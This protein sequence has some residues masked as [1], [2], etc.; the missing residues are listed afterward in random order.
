[1]FVLQYP[2][3]VRYAHI[4]P[5]GQAA[6]PVVPHQER[7]GRGVQAGDP[8]GL[9]RVRCTPGAMASESK[10][11]AGPLGSNYRAVCVVVAGNE[12]TDGAITRQVRDDVSAALLEHSDVYS[13]ITRAQL[14]EYAK[15]K[16]WKPSDVTDLLR[17]LRAFMAGD[18]AAEQT[19]D[20][21][22]TQLRE[23]VEGV[24]AAAKPKVA[25]GQLDPA[26]ISRLLGRDE[27]PKRNPEPR[28]PKELTRIVLL[29]DFPANAKEAEAILAVTEVP[30]D[31][32]LDGMSN[33]QRF[34]HAVLEFSRSSVSLLPR[35]PNVRY[36]CGEEGQQR[37]T[38][39]RPNA[40]DGN[41]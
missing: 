33:T 23:Q 34:L 1:M 22:L 16:K 17:A 40:G 25:K 31:S 11:D 10:G 32:A 3:H 35:N 7:A 2:T 36:A 6:T 4:Q 9:V 30:A 5:S 19:A 38:R 26:T 24:S 39:G 37:L 13:T 18:A 15:L 20:Q 27:K 41:P 21:V 8:T 28:P 29:H 12:S 14:E